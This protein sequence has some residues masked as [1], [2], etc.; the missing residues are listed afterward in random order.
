MVQIFE[1][2]EVREYP[3]FLTVEVEEGEIVADVINNMNS[4]KVYLLVDHDTKRIWTYN[5]QN[6]SFKLQFYGGILAGMLRKQLK[7]F[8]RVY[9]LNMY[10]TEDPE[11]Q[12]IMVKTIG[13]GRAKTIDKKDFSKSKTQGTL[14]NVAIHNP[15]LNKALENINFFSTPEDFNRIFLIVAGTIYTDEETPKSFF[16]EEESSVNLVK[17]GRLNN[18]FTFFNDRNYSTRVVVKKRSIQGI[19][20][21][22]HNSDKMPVVRIKT[23]IIHEEKISKK[24]SIDKLLAAFDI[25][26]SLP[27]VENDDDDDENDEEEITEGEN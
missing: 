5:G 24:G 13:P 11:F 9:P 19:E 20:L 1:I 2:L 23:P 3:Y 8:Y 4:R 16:S 12:K 7:L 15:R 18:G 17:M 21:F 26:E 25:P 14:A 22:V 27:D 10:S 6:S